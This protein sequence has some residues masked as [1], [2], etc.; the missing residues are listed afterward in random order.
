MA[1]YFSVFCFVRISQPHVL[2][3][4]KDEH[5]VCKILTTSVPFHARFFSAV[6][7]HKADHFDRQHSKNIFFFSVCIHKIRLHRG[8]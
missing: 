1:V 5:K 2:L 8:K 6:E 7:N 4:Q 3:L